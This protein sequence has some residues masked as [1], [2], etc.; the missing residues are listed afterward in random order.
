MFVD[1]GVFLAEASFGPGS[2][3]DPQASLVGLFGRIFS[4]RLRNSSSNKLMILRIVDV[5][6]F[7]PMLPS[8]S[9]STR[10]LQASFIVFSRGCMFCNFLLTF[11]PL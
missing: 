10:D 3:R 5:E 6:V 11:D 4:L 2:L 9:G 1:V 8:G 7:L